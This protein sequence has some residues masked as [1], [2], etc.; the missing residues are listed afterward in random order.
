M[1]VSTGIG[2]LVVVIGSAVTVGSTMDEGDGVF[3]NDW[4]ET[5]LELLLQPSN[6]I[7]IIST[8]TSE[9]SFRFITVNLVSIKLFYHSC[10]LID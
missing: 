10:F 5:E 1:A 8:K 9:I 6:S 7:E 4:T 2:L 3:G